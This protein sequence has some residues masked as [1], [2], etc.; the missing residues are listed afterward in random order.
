MVPTDGFSELQFTF[1]EGPWYYFGVE[2]LQQVDAYMCG[3]WVIPHTRW[4][5]A[6]NV[7]C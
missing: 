4:K 7:A 5:A 1:D 2:P 3:G 6:Q